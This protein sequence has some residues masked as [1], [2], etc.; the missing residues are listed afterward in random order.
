MS[1]WP[2]FLLLWLRRHD[3]FARIPYRQQF[4]VGVPVRMERGRT[5]ERSLV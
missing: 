2:C 5:G 4:A 1:F 3:F